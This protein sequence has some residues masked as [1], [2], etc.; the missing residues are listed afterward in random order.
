MLRVNRQGDTEFYMFTSSVSREFV[1]TGIILSEIGVYKERAL[2]EIIAS[3]VLGF[4]APKRKKKGIS[5]R[6]A[7]SRDHKRKLWVLS[8][9]GS[10]SNRVHQ[11]RS[12]W[13]DRVSLISFRF[14]SAGAL[15]AVFGAPLTDDIPP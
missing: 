13:F 6:L 1:R 11:H 3:R 10:M 2:I 9:P 14:G 4:T 7:C 8:F 12:L 5:G 15:F